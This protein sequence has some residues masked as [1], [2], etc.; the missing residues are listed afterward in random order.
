MT[1]EREPSSNDDDASQKTSAPAEA[2]GQPWW[3]NNPQI[4]AARKEAL[5]WLL[6]AEDR[7]ILSDEPD[8]VVM[9]LYSGTSSRELV[10]ARDNL[11]RAR[12]RYEEAIRA[13]RTAGWSWGEIGRLLGVPRQ[14]LHR[15]F[16]DEV[17]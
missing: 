17:D 5:G 13:A 2:T 12:G 8:P 14:L 10:A 6:S 16:R 15:R 9:D 7:P 3:Q 4:E 1:I 11:D